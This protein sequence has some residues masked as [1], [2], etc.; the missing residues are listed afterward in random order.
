[1]AE[2]RI[3]H[4]S[5]E[6]LEFIESCETAVYRDEYA[7]SEKYLQDLLND[8]REFA[9]STTKHREDMWVAELEGEPVGVIGLKRTFEPDTGRIA[10]LAVPKGM[11]KKGVGTHL[12]EVALGSAVEWEYSKLTA[13]IPSTLRT[14]ILFFIKNGFS[15][16][17][18]E[19]RTEWRE[20]P[21]LDE[22]WELKLSDS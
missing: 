9:T 5:E 6:D 22:T 2:L 20:T 18:T 21:V 4:C 19:E 14:G 11:R 3:R 10:F 15:L 1:M 17:K 12:M 16:V 7:F 8:V 13:S